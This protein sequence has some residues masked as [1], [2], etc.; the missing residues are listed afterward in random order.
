MTRETGTGAQ[1][2]A[3]DSRAAEVL[4]FWFRGPEKRKAWFEKDPAFDASIRDR[5]LPLY[6]TAAGGGLSAWKR[7]AG[8]CLALVVVLD[9]FPRNM[10]RGS[11]RAFAA[12]PLARD[13]ANHAIALGFDKAMLPVERQFLY[14]PLEH[15]ESLADQERCLELMREIAVFPETADLPKWAQ[16]HLDIIRRFGRFPHRND[17]LGRQSN[18]AEIEF[19]KEPGSS[20]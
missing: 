14:L 9:Q 16:A 2:V 1:F 6:E 13:C 12:D 19:L 18:P 11:A 17:I 7:S 4:S 5:F 10:F 3:R 15:S 8:D 20:F